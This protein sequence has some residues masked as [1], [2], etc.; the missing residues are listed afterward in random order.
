MPVGSWFR[1]FP[2][3]PSLQFRPR[4]ERLETRILFNVSPTDVTG[5]GT[6]GGNGPPVHTMTL[7]SVSSSSVVSGSTNVQGLVINI[8]ATGTSASVVINGTVSAL[9]TTDPPHTDF[10]MAVINDTT[11]QDLDEFVFSNSATSAAFNWSFT[12]PPGQT[13]LRYEARKVGALPVSLTGTIGVN[14]IPALAQN[15][16][17][18]VAEGGTVTIGQSRL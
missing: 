12:V 18:T 10:E 13:P 15:T 9:G 5:S 2:P 14:R 4:L 7:T 16:G 11:D 3:K 8:A 6:F 17:A 1:R